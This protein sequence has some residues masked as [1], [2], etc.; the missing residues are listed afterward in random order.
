MNQHNFDG[1]VFATTPH[2]INYLAQTVNQVNIQRFNLHPQPHIITQNVPVQRITVPPP[3]VTN[4]MLNPN[5]QPVQNVLIQQSP[6]PI[7]QVQ[8]PTQ[9]A[10]QKREQQI[11]R[12]LQTFKK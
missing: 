10:F 2:Q 5:P 3:S 4:I 6:P 9:T 11:T 1:R 12:N 8:V 7:Q